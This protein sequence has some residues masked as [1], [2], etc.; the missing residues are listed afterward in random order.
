M[1]RTTAALV[2]VALSAMPTAA[3]SPVERCVAARI[4]VANCATAVAETPNNPAL[5]RLYAMSLARTGQYHAA[6]NQYR[7]VTRLAPRDGRGFYEHAWML[8]FLR[9][10]AEAIEPIERSISLSPDHL[11]SYR[12]AAI[13]YDLVKRP[14]DLFRVALAGA[15]LGDVIA[16][17]DTHVCYAKGRGTARDDAQALAWLVRAA[18]GGHVT[19]M[20][21]L[22]Q[23]YLNGGLGESPDTA[24][25]EDWASRARRARRG[26]RL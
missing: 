6:V 11:P 3:E 5:R 22:V 4:D 12:A 9:R 25:A 7:E 18:E 20:D 15:N 21:E 19:A 1:I 2:V 24:R 10:Y 13:I 14:N 23:M 17:Y 16:M 8:A 26:G